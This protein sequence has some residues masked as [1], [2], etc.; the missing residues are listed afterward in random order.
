MKKSGTVLMIGGIILLILGTFI[1]KNLNYVNSVDSHPWT[2][3]IN[4]IKSFSWITFSG[5]LFFVIGLIFNISSH[6]KK[7]E[8]IL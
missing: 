3:N 1:F 4:G 8:R 2:I 6:V 5:G 7:G